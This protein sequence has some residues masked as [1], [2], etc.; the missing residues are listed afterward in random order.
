M[1]KA[2]YREMW[3]ETREELKL[4]D[5][6]NKDLKAE[7]I[8]LKAEVERITSDYNKLLVHCTALEQDI[9]DSKK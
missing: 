7:N 9:E 3:E 8:R 6:E 1:D 4:V 5:E 2:Y